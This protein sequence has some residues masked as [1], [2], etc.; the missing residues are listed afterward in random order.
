MGSCKQDKVK[1]DVY[2][3][4]PVLVGDWRK[5][6]E[7]GSRRALN[8][9]QKLNLIPGETWP[10]HLLGVYPAGNGVLGAEAWQQCACRWACTWKTDIYHSEYKPRVMNVLARAF[11][12][13][14]K[15]PQTQKKK[16]NFS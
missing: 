10:R 9:K 6:C 1:R 8:G 11:E 4:K 7:T 5:W 15:E 16:G 14:D 13:S 2:W 3:T 12:F